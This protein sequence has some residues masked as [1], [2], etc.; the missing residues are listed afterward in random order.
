MQTSL[1]VGNVHVQIAAAWFC[2]TAGLKGRGTFENVD[3]TFPV[4]KVHPAGECGLKMAMQILWRRVSPELQFQMA[5]HLMDSVSVEG[6][7]EADDERNGWKTR[8][9]GRGT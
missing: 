2:E 3:C 1:E 6:E 9:M 8:K 5:R 7:P 4:H